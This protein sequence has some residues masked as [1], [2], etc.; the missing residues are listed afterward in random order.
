MRTRQR[1]FAFI[2]A[3]DGEGRIGDV[4]APAG[5]RAVAGPRRS[6]AISTQSRA[7][8]RALPWPVR[9]FLLSIPLPWLFSIGPLGLS[10]YRL[11]LLVMVP[12]CLFQWIGGK[13]GRIRLPDIAFILFVCWCTL[14]ICVI[15]GVSYAVQ[16]AGMMA[17]ETLGAYF[18]GRCYIRSAADMRNAVKL[19]FLIVAAIFPFAAIESISGHNVLKD[20][21][22]HVLPVYIDVDMNPR[23][24]L[25]RAQAT[26]AHPILLGLFGGCSLALVHMI[27]G[28]GEPPAR[29]WARTGIVAGTAFFS[30]SA[31]PITGLMGQTMLLGWRWLLRDVQ[32]KWTILISFLAFSAFAAQLLAN[33]SLPVIF[34]DFFAFD[35]ASAYIRIL[36]WRFGTE[37]IMNH[38]LF[39]VGFGEWDRPEWMPSSI[40]MYWIIDTVRHGLPAGFL[41]LLGFFS[42]VIGVALKKGLDAEAGTC[43]TAYVITMIGFFLVGWTVYIWTSVYVLM[44]FLLGGG[45]WILDADAGSPSGRGTIRRSKGEAV[46]A[47]RTPSG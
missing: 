24:G 36:I 45:M 2:A 37:S 17:I 23:W 31:G 29:R 35:E 7:T 30:L 25:K 14:A 46:R 40:D 6:P 16:P 20:A 32:A 8:V 13:A 27:L 22:S 9:L 39:G 34:I 42:A 33:R 1:R 19:V 10:A 15:H 18:L 38:P 5:R 41:L 21:L 44:L 12:P 4:S 28:D 43:R 26:F 3:G 47:G 11:V